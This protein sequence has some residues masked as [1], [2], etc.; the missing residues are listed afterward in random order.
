MRGAGPAMSLY[1]IVTKCLNTKFDR[2]KAMICSLAL[3]L[4]LGQMISVDESPTAPWMRLT[5]RGIAASSNCLP[6]PRPMASSVT[7]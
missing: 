7:I 2:L 4:L 3:K 6:V 1:K 5:N